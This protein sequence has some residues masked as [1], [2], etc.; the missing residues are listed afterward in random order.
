[1]SKPLPKFAANLG[2]LFTEVPFLQRFSAAKAAG[3]DAVE[4]GFDQYDHSLDDVA[5]ALKDNN[6]SCVLLNAPKAKD[7]NLGVGATPGKE[8]EFDAAIARA[9]T[10]CK[11]LSCPLLH[12]MSGLAKDDVTQQQQV[13]VFVANLKRQAAEAHKYGVTMTL[14]PIS[15]AAL[16]GYF[17]NHIDVALAVVD[18][19]AEQNVKYQFDVFHAQKT[20]GDLTGTLKRSI[21]RLAHVQIS[22]LPDRNEPDENGEVNIHYLIRLLDELGYEGAIGCEYKPATD[23]VSGLK[24]MQLYK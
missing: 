9:L 8:A 10:Y 13:D 18:A 17:N 21:D 3:F 22:G 24:W 15:A 2:F 6:L 19:T 16:P 20:H 7:G 4:L 11:A 23:T 1:M 5:R 14:E 12:V